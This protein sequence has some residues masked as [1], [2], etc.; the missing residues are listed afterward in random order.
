MAVTKQKKEELLSELTKKFKDAKVAVLTDYRGLDVESLSK[1][2][3]DAFEKQID[4]KVAKNTLFILAAKNAGIKVDEAAFTRP[5]GVAF[6]YNDEVDSPKLVNEFSKSNETFEIVGGI[7][8]GE[9]VPKEKVL[10]L[11]NLPSREELYA[12]IVG[13]LASPLRGIASVLQGNLRGLV[14]VLDQYKNKV[15]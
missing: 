15:Q 6:G 10:D 4:Y 13:S 7:I 12:K 5:I 2:R 14:S 11:A 3:K 1:F 9:F 8:N